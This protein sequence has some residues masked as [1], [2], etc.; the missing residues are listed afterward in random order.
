M[1]LGLG[2]VILAAGESTRM[3]RDKALLAWP[4]PVLSPSPSEI[5]RGGGGLRNAHPSRTER[6]KN[7]APASGIVSAG[8][9]LSAAIQALSQFCDMVIVVAGKNALALEPIAY[10]CGAFL[11]RNP[12]PERGQFSSLQTGLQEVLSRGR[13]SAMVTLV[14]R[15]P[16]SAETLSRLAGEFQ[17]KEHSVWAVVPEYQGKHGHP[18]LIGRELM[19]AFL[20][21]PATTNARE[22]EHANQQRIVYLAVE[23]PVVAA[24]VDTPDDYA[25]L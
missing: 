14:D 3:G 7:G 24:N 17:K 21:A 1:S 12:D 2:G 22:I 6:E 23:D 13:D 25:K 16:P 8:T 15:P 20:R 18:I 19:E 5:E 11:V 10:G 9:V 4:P